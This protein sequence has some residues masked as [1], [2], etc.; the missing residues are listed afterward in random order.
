MDNFT[1]AV[2]VSDAVMILA[3]ITLIVVDRKKPPIEAVKPAAGK[4]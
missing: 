1:L 4:R 2:V 3:F